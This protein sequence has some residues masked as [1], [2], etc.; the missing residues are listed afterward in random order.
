MA[1]LLPRKGPAPRQKNR[2]AAPQGPWQARGQSSDPGTLGGK[3]LPGTLA[4]GRRDRPPPA[5]AG[6]AGAVARVPSLPAIPQLKPPTHNTPLPLAVAAAAS[7][8]GGARPAGPA[9]VTCGAT[10][11]AGAWA[12]S[13]A[14]GLPIRHSRRRRARTLGA[15]RTAMSTLSTLEYCRLRR[16]ASHSVTSRNLKCEVQVPFGPWQ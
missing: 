9:M 4:A 14:A 16:V 8:G 7:S 2:R 11:E 3:R 12:V 6:R 13:Y 1:G 10:V 15:R 5:R